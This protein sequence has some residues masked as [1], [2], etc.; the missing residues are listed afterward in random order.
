MKIDWIGFGHFNLQW[1]N[2]SQWLQSAGTKLIQILSLLLMD[3]W[4][5]TNSGMTHLTHNYDSSFDS[6]KNDKGGLVCCWNIK[7][8]EHPERVYHTKSSALSVSFSQ[9]SPNLLA[10]DLIWNLIWP[11]LTLNNL[12]V[13]VGLYNGVILIYNVARS[14][15][16]IAIDSYDSTGK[17]T[18]PCWQLEWV[19][20]E[21]GNDERYWWFIINHMT[22]IMTY[23]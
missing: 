11:H 21:R 12:W 6:G 22:H 16:L 1:Q 18:G 5:E 8:L 4:N 20:R 9:M 2:H 7:N 15:D 19:E 17:H 13:I 23:I 3:K 14:E 10:G